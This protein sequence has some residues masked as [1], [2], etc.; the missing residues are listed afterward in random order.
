MDILLIIS[1][2]SSLVFYLSWLMDNNINYA[3]K[4]FAVISSVI[5]LFSFLGLIPKEIITNNYETNFL[6]TNNVNIKFDKTVFI[7]EKITKSKYGTEITNKVEYEIFVEK[8]P[9]AN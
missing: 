4:I 8:T 3:I 5:F 9:N 1:S 6:K 2:L 7:Q